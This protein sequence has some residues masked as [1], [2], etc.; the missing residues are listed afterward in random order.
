MPYE[1][2]FEPDARQ[3]LRGMS[4]YDRAIVVAAIDVQLTHTPAEETRHRKQ[5]DASL[6]GTWE[7]RVG[8]FRVFYDV[9]ESEAVLL[10]HA[11]GVK[12]H[13]RLTVGGKEWTL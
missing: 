9:L 8:D 7:L 11:I 13:N 6:L 12:S 1:I 10:I 3:H 5:I 2:R 4:A